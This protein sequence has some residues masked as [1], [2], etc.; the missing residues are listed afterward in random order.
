MVTGHDLL[1]LIG[2]EVFKRVDRNI[3]EQTHHV[4]AFKIDVLH[5]E[6]LIEENDAVLP[7]FLLVAPVG[8]FGLVRELVTARRRV[9][10]HFD[11]AGVLLEFGFEAR[12]FLGVHN[13]GMFK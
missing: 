12:G 4:R 10:Q 8:V 3:R 9:A 11:R 5:V 7:S 2:A 1:G 13:F 6:G